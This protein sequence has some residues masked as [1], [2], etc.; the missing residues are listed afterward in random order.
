MFKKKKMLLTSFFHAW[1]H[2]EKEQENYKKKKARKQNKGGVRLGYV[3]SL[4]TIKWNALRI[5][6]IQSVCV[7]YIIT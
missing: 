6:H 3:M 7:C 5:S 4:V 2:M 1:L